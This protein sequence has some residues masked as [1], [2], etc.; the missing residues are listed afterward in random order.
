MS[1]KLSHLSNAFFNHYPE[2]E[3]QDIKNYCET[4]EDP[5]KW[6]EVFTGFN[7]LK[8]GIESIDNIDCDMVM[9]V[10]KGVC[11]EYAARKLKPE[12]LQYH[13][14]SFAAFDYYRPRLKRQ[15]K[16]DISNLSQIN[17]AGWLFCINNTNQ[18]L[19]SQIF[20]RTKVDAI[21]FHNPETNAAGV[22]FRVNGVL[23]QIFHPL[24]KKELLAKLREMEEGWTSIGDDQNLIINHG[25]KN[26][27]RSAVS[28]QQ[29]TELVNNILIN[30]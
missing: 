6:D 26:K 19:T 27:T 30:M 28:T 11:F 12:H 17:I 13:I 14:M 25:H 1:V 20:R 22:I 3:A 4:S 15:S 18:N 8:W 21:I 23:N 5:D 2:V 24:A 10:F 16:V 29:L 9:P 7:S